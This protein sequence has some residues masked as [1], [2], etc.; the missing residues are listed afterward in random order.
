[1]EYYVVYNILLKNIKYECNDKLKAWL[2]DHHSIF[3][4]HI[5]RDNQNNDSTSITIK[6]LG[7][8]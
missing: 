7:E 2:Y 3:R 1:M 5:N 6:I 8:I 4:H